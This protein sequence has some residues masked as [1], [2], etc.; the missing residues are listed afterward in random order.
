MGVYRVYG[1]FG[2]RLRFAG[3]SINLCGAVILY[4]MLTIEFFQ[5]LAP[6]K[7]YGCI[8]YAPLDAPDDWYD[9]YEAW[10]FDKTGNVPPPPGYE[11]WD[12]EAALEDLE[13]E[14]RRVEG[15]I[16]QRNDELMRQGRQGRGAEFGVKS[17]ANTGTASM[18]PDPPR[19]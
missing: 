1:R 16:C 12:M 11:N 2:C 13:R 14:Q 8:L 18:G 7:P 4:A 9:Q 15:L 6:G 3:F 5:H 19:A 10:Q 17:G